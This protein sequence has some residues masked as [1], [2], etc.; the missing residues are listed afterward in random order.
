V[1]PAAALEG[2]GEDAT[3]TGRHI[4]HAVMLR[5][6]AKPLELPDERL[7]YHV[8]ESDK[9]ALALVDYATANE[10]D[11]ILIG[12]PH[13]LASVRLFLSVAES[14]VRDAPC[15]VKVVRARPPG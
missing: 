8:L 2:E 14:V 11:E 13:R 10:V 6:W 4:K 15:S 1:P 12:A 3:A 7:T 5:Q 9:P